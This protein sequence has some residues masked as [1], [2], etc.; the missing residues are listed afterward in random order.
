M[1]RGHIFRGQL[2]MM[3]VSTDLYSCQAEHATD[4]LAGLAWGPLFGFSLHV[5]LRRQKVR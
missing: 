3:S 1:P 5:I 2:R 4:G